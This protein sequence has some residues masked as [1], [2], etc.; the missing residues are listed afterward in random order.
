MMWGYCSANLELVLVSSKKNFKYN[1]TFSSLSDKFVAN[2]FTILTAAYILSYW[3]HFY[4]CMHLCKKFLKY[5]LVKGLLPP[6]TC[7]GLPGSA[8]LVLGLWEC[9][10]MAGFS[11]P[12]RLVQHVVLEIEPGSLLLPGRHLYHRAIS[13]AHAPFKNINGSIL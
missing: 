10:T 3:R 8:F 4:A 1:M 7:S 13:P 12:L 6:Q 2:I 5:H 9:V 11:G